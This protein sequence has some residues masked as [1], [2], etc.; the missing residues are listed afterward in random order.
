MTELATT[1]KGSS[2]FIRL[3]LI[4][5]TINIFTSIA[6]LIITYA[7]ILDSTEKRAKESIIQQLSTISV[8]FQNRYSN[9]LRLNI[10]SFAIHL[11]DY[12]F[13][14]ESEQ[15]VLARN[16]GY[17]FLKATEG[18]SHYQS[19]SFINREGDVKIATLG[20][21][22][23]VSHPNYREIAKS[24][25]DALSAAQHAQLSLYQH[26]QSIPL[27]LRAGYMD[28]FIPER[29]IETRGPFLTTENT[30]SFVAG[31]AKLD[32]DT[33]KSAG[34]LIIQQ[35]LSIFFNSLK[36]FSILDANPIW[37]LTPDGQILQQPVHASPELNP[38]LSL[39]SNFQ[40]TIKTL[41]TTHGFIVYQD[42]SIV[43][44]KS[45]FRV[46]VSIPSRLI[47]K[48]FDAVV[49]FLAITLFISILVIFVVSYLVSKYLS[50]PIISLAKATEA[51]ATGA[52][53]SEVSINAQGEVGTL[54]SSFNFMI[55]ELQSKAQL[56]KHVEDRT[57]DLEIANSEIIAQKAAEKEILK[58][59]E[60]AEK[61]SR[62]KSEFL[63]VMSHEIRTP[64]NGVIGMADLLKDTG[65][66]AEQTDMLNKIEYSGNLLLSIIN[67]ILD[68]SKIEAGKLDLHPE[69]FD[70]LGFIQDLSDI[71][72]VQASAKDLDI[73]CNVDA[74]VPA[75]IMADPGRLGQ[76]LTNLIGNAI[77]FSE[78]G[79]IEV[80]VKLVEPTY[81]QNTLEPKTTF[82]VFEITD[83]GIGIAPEDQKDLFEAFSQ[84]DYSTTR[85]KGGT[86]LGLAICKA[87]VNCWGGIINV[88]SQLGIGSKFWFTLPLVGA[89][90]GGALPNKAR[91]N[92][93]PDAKSTHQQEIDT[94][95]IHAKVLLVEDNMVNQAVAKKM[96]CRLGCTVELAENG[97][98]ALNMIKNNAGYDL[99]LM[100]CQMPVMDGYTATKKL[101]EYEMDMDI[102]PNIV[103]ALTANVLS[104]DQ[105]NCR[106][107][108]MNDFLPKPL[109]MD[110]L[111]ELLGRWLRNGT[112]FSG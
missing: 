7:F 59:K 71:L 1:K 34:A 108:G 69:I 25:L 49:R 87:L 68:Y 95:K 39:P 37:I 41:D 62:A 104:S 94:S 111:T 50:T 40:G 88:D 89:N 97:L 98:E 102:A 90:A 17:F 42:F 23:N 91:L 61:A 92:K 79:C 86:G 15:E 45:L 110:K 20:N 30:Y 56:E 31:L 100:D 106:S 44:G 19:V 73:I 67:D 65:L 63:A 46:A 57:R 5:L 74:N 107:C 28:W 64:M 14:S 18:L 12:L 52:L 72:Q 35:D 66:N 96:L 109:K 82:L 48:D 112:Q 83:H 32:L 3:L 22:R 24:P 36:E 29:E 105:E 51:F 10:K 2:I 8:D 9:L 85:K 4:F 16:I 70:C 93:S 101:R 13:A 76:V 21:R 99:I 80:N 75:F 54:V 38:N 103:V 60:E 33:G 58:A 43:P 81:S 11:D 6:L 55:R 27:M 77:K 47:R 26:L 84:V 53:T 78:K